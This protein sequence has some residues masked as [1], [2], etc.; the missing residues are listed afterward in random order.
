MRRPRPPA[1]ANGA[2]DAA[3]AVAGARRGGSD[4]RRR[5]AGSPPGGWAAPRPNGQPT[6]HYKDRLQEE[7]KWKQNPS[8][9]SNERLWATWGPRTATKCTPRTLPAGRQRGA[10]VLARARAR[11]TQRLPRRVRLSAGS[12]P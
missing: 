7:Y 12:F 3:D 5:A 8:R 6:I 4:A 2:R 11:V 1:T 9:G 10:G